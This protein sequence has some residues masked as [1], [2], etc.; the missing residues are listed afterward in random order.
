MSTTL[1]DHFY[2]KKNFFDTKLYKVNTPKHKYVLNIK[3]TKSKY[4]L[5]F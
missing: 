3:H 4:L 5:N 1:L 2:L